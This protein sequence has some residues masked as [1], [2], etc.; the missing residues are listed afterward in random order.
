M[1]MET[2]DE[3]AQF[4]EKLVNPFLGRVII[5]KVSLHKSLETL[6]LPP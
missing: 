5:S 1:C 2:L 6:Y 3:Y 4:S